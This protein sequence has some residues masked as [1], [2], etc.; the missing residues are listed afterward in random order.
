M[1]KI[2]T[3][4]VIS[5]L[6]GVATMLTLMLFSGCMIKTKLGAMP[7]SPTNSDHPGVIPAYPR[8]RPSHP[9]SSC[10][11]PVT[12]FGLLRGASMVFFRIKMLP[13]RER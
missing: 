13:V 9:N 3:V 7:G 6:S 8:W 12:R 10:L 1:R 4:S 11:L 2:T 5:V